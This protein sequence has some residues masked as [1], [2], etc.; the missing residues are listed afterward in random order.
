MLPPFLTFEITFIHL[1]IRL[2]VIEEDY[3][4]E[5]TVESCNLLLQKLSSLQALP[6]EC[7]KYVGMSRSN[8]AQIKGDTATSAE[9]VDP[10]QGMYSG[11]KAAAIAA[12]K[13]GRPTHA[14]IERRYTRGAAGVRKDYD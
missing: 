13:S 6:V 1:F 14:V 2:F 4:H 11:Q 10:F 12:R 7:R 5:Y 9:G 8:K 3:V